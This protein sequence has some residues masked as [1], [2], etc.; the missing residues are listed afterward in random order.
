VPIAKLSIAGNHLV[1]DEVTF[2][3]AKPKIVNGGKGN[4]KLKGSASLG[5]Y[6]YGK[7]GKDKID[8]RGGNDTVEGGKGVDKVKGGDGDDTLIAGSGSDTLEGGAGSDTFVFGAIDGVAK[9]KD[10]NPVFDTI[11]LAQATFF[12]L[13]KGN[14]SAEHL[15]LGAAATEADDRLIYD[16]ATGNLGY[17]GDGTGPGA[18]RV[19]AKLPAGLAL[20]VGDFI[21]A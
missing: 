2:D 21:V 19:F 9:L 8:G 14:P 6:I 1:V 11:F 4:D 18:L 20:S 3:T 13:E 17:D 10:F 5:D 7:G 16:P 15:A 12:G